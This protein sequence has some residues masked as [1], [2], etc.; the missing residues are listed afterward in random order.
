MPRAAP[1]GAV[2][3]AAIVS[4]RSWDILLK[5]VG[6]IL[7]WWLGPIVKVASR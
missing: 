3:T 4:S 2:A 5:R 1:P 6:T 7:G